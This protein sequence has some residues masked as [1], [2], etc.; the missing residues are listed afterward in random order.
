MGDQTFRL[1]NIV[2]GRTDASLFTIPADFKV[3]D[4]NQ[5]VE[6]DLLPHASVG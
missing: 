5:P 3:L 1:T 4:S 2:R 6:D